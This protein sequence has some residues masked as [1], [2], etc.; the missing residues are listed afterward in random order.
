MSKKINGLKARRN[1]S[2][3]PETNDFL[4]QSGINVSQFVENAAKQLMMNVTDKHDLNIGTL[5]IVS[6]NNETKHPIIPETTTIAKSKDNALFEVEG[7]KSADSLP[8]FFRRNF[9]FYLKPESW[10]TKYKAPHADIY[11]NWLKSE[12]KGGIDSSTAKNY[13]SAAR[14]RP[15]K[16]PADFYNYD[17]VPPTEGGIKIPG[18]QITEHTQ[19]MLSIPIKGGLSKF[20][21]FCKKVLRIEYLAGHSISEWSLEANNAPC[22]NGNRGEQKRPTTEEIIM[23]YNALPNKLR[24]FFIMLLYCGCRIEQLARAL[25][26]EERKFEVI[27]PESKEVLGLKKEILYMDCRSIA[28][29]HKQALGFMLPI[30]LKD[31]ASKVTCPVQKDG[32]PFV[33]NAGIAT[34]ITNAL[35]HVRDPEKRITAKGTRKWQ[36][37]AICDA[38]GIVADNEAE[39]IALERD[40]ELVQGRGLGDTTGNENYRRAK[41]RVA[42]AF[43]KVVDILVS[44]FPIPEITEDENGNIIFHNIPL[45]D[46]S[47]EVPVDNLNKE[48]FEEYATMKV[49]KN[50]VMANRFTNRE[51]M[52]M[53][54]ISNNTVNKWCKKLNIDRG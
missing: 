27:T 41:A 26:M 22:G 23:G 2:L 13:A 30:E 34:T 19:E 54:G 43:S 18:V 38:A 4:K 46:N 48:D 31:I 42:I 7:Y 14:A 11:I 8:E 6:N 24:G 3:S 1:I 10:D 21:E 36:F 50:G 16:K 37:N 15:I 53:F 9:Y 35:S 29:G 12:K 32:T 52:I 25:Q 28:K 45:G 39:R 5:L 49:N 33:N 44:E 51:L 47:D 17:E 20:I 40:M